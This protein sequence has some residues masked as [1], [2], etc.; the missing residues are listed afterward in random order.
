MVLWSCY[1]TITNQII[2][3]LDLSKCAKKSGPSCSRL[4]QLNMVDSQRSVQYSI[5]HANFFF[6][7]TKAVFYI[8]FFITSK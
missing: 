4:L 6:V 8:H 5:N 7:K 2:H 1:L 3:H